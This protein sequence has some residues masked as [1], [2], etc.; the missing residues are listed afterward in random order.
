MG[1][2]GELIMCIAWPNMCAEFAKYLFIEHLHIWA[3]VLG[4]ENVAPASKD[5]K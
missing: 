2:I 1:L 3:I 4:P 5:L